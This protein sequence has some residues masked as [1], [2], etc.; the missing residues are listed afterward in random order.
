M[1]SSNDIVYLRLRRH[2]AL[3]SSAVVNDTWLEIVAYLDE[4]TPNV[5][6][7]VVDGNTHKCAFSSAEF[8]KIR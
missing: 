5:G 4:L 8:L 2:V 3:S 1:G 6:I 7:T